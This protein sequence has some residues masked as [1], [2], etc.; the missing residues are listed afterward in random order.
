MQAAVRHLKV[1]GQDDVDAIRVHQDRGG[2]LHHLLDRLHA[3]PQA[4]E[5]A[6]GKGMQAHVQD[7]LHIAGEEHRRAAGLE[8]VV[9]LVRGRGG[10]ADVV[11]ARDRDHAA[12]LGRAR[13]IGVLEHVGAAVHARPL[14]IPDAEDAVELLGLGI[15][16]E[17]L[18]APDGRGAQLFV[19]AGLKD[20][21]I[22]LHMLFGGPQDWS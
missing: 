7:V 9:A 21:V 3:R 1:F 20:D 2:G 15:E 19:H 18:R 17:L 10:L 12:M 16:I 4:R 13:H 22:R 11:V 14:A 6:H 5:T 8:D